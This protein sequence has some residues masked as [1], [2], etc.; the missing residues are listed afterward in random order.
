MCHGCSGREGLL[1]TL[2]SRPGRCLKPHQRPGGRP[3]SVP[4]IPGDADASL[5]RPRWRTHVLPAPDLGTS[6]RV[7]PRQRPGGRPTPG[8]QIPR[9]ADARTLPLKKFAL[10]LSDG[11][12]YCMFRH[13]T[14]RRKRRP[15][16]PPSPPGQKG[17]RTWATTWARSPCPPVH[18]GRRAPWPGPRPGPGRL[19]PRSTGAEG[20]PSLATTWARA[21]CPRSIGAEARPVLG[22]VA[23]PPQSTGAEGRPDLGQVALPP[24]PLGQKGA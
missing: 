23:L 2:A 8:P 17:A 1:P 12:P 14:R 22:H 13:H 5:S 11:P 15:S 18:R 6:T 10:P 21:P 16:S 9:A 4:R 20:R 7:L 19:A 3:R 24:G